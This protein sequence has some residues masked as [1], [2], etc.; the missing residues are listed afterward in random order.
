MAPFKEFFDAAY[1]ARL[2]AALSQDL[3]D[4][5]AFVAQAGAALDSLELKDRVA[6]ISD[7]LNACL[8]GDFDARVSALERLLPDARRFEDG[9]A[10]FEEGE[11]RGMAAWP[12]VRVVERHG[13]AHPQR[14][15]RAMHAMT[16]RF[17]AEFAIR[18]FLL[19]RRDEA[20][21]VLREWA[22][23][24][25][26]HVR[27]LVSEGSRPRLPWS[28]QLGFAIA[29]PTPGLELIEPLV[30]DESAYVRRSVANHL[31][32]VSK[33]HPDVA[34]AVAGR[35]LS[36]SAE[37]KPLVKHALRGL[38]KAGHPGALAVLGFKA[39]VDAR[40]EGLRCSPQVT[41]GEHAQL[42]VTLVSG[43]EAPEPLVVDYAVHH[44]KASGERTA[45]VFKWTVLELA[46]GARRVLKRKHSFKRIT[47]RRYY[48]GVHGVEL[49]LNGVPHGMVEFVLG[50]DAPR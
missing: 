40:A 26:E 43:S 48:P 24:P 14:S 29:D 10:D 25:S 36:G 3:Q 47:T 35:W 2:G 13:L 42:E 20:F 31:N 8:R 4:E 5:A 30:D 34:V 33:D 23:D 15:Y 12:L 22:S 49:L 32:D 41:V 27:R 38:I 7:A 45:K 39:E 46:P 9:L 11:W 6:Q 44:V 17:T 19:E 16:Q 50:D 18:P 28:M 37:R 1:V 21:A